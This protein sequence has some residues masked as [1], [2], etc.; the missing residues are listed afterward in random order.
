MDARKHIARLKVLSGKPSF[1]GDGTG[2]GYPA[3][4]L[5]NFGFVFAKK[6]RGNPLEKVETK[7]VPLITPILTTKIRARECL[8]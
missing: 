3:N 5:L 1:A 2:L 7:S 6:N 8:R 4:R